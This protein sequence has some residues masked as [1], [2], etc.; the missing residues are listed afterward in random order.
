[1]IIG[2]KICLKEI[3]VNQDNFKVMKSN[4][5]KF[6]YPSV[7]IIKFKGE[8]EEIEIFSKVTNTY[9]NAICKCAINEWNGELNPQLVMVDYEIVEKE[10]NSILDSWGF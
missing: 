10:N 8:D 6:S 9:I 7:D 3:P 5:L 1:M 4:T 2:E